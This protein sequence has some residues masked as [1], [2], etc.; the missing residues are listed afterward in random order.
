MKILRRFYPILLT[1]GLFAHPASATP[2]D[3]INVR[4]EVF[5]LSGDSIFLLRSTHDNLGV[6]NAEHRDVF[7]V[8][9]DRI[10]GEETLW[11]VYRA[12]ARTE[13]GGGQ[14]PGTTGEM[15]AGSVNPFEMLRERGGIALG[16]AG[17]SAGG[18]VNIEG[19]HVSVRFG[20]GTAI[21]IETAPLLRR[22]TTSLDGLATRIGDYDRL[23]PVTVGE[24]LSGQAFELA[25][26]TFAEAIQYTGSPR[27]GPTHLIRVTCTQEGQ[28][29]SLLLPVR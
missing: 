5:G 16:A 28:V 29:A 6:Y 27:T 12:R 21:R 7:F 3:T 4:D 8:A 24:L 25:A 13:E 15:L 18:P 23:A 10:S 2:P 9:I 11:P 26:C 19:R 22:M 14:R 17:W 1:V 20:E